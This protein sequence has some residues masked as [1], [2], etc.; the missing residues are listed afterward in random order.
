MSVSYVCFEYSQ[1]FLVKGLTSECIVFWIRSFKSEGGSKLLACTLHV[2]YI[3]IN[4]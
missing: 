2:C 4:A 1:Y 3:K